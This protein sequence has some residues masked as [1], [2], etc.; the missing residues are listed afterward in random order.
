MSS[1]APG[2]EKPQPNAGVKDGEEMDG[3]LINEN[4]PSNFASCSP[5]WDFCWRTSFGLAAFE[6]LA[7][8]LGA[9]LS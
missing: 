4:A 1:V 8:S 2:D 7:R 6:H 9:T 5:P 3:Y